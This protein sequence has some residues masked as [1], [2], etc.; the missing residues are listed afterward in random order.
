MAIAAWQDPNAPLTFENV[1]PN[2]KSVRLDYITGG[3][4]PVAGYSG[5]PAYGQIGGDL[6]TPQHTYRTIQMPGVRLGAGGQ[7]QQD[8][9]LLG[10][11]RRRFKWALPGATEGEFRE[12]DVVTDPDTGEVTYEKRE[13]YKVVSE[14]EMKRWW[15]KH[16]RKYIK[17]TE[18]K[19]KQKALELQTQQQQDY[20]KW[21]NEERY[22]YPIHHCFCTCFDPVGLI[23]NHKCNTL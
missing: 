17:R 11:Y 3:T 4:V 6:T 13:D 5:N 7:A 20:A 21:W 1:L 10:D 18:D 23:K 22:K 9:M 19:Y 15:S 14:E 2:P 12:Y 16:S 8:A